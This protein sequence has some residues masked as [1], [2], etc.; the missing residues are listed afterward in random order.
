MDTPSPNA[1]IQ[2][3]DEREKLNAGG[4]FHLQ[5]QSLGNAMEE[6]WRWDLLIS[7]SITPFLDSRR[8]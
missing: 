2:H 3:T 4:S 5:D 6:Y 1:M 8:F 7:S